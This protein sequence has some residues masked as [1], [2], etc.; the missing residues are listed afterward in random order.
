MSDA[1][2]T[3][4]LVHVAFADASSW[5][6]VITRLQAR[7]IPVTAPAN[8]LRGI[9]ADS[10]YLA[11]VLEQIDGPVTASTTSCTRSARVRRARVSALA[12]RRSVRPAK[13]ELGCL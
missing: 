8:P 13:S 7:G 10:A 9:S 1:T 6:G 2:P 11:S 4:V 5:N 3:V 12:E